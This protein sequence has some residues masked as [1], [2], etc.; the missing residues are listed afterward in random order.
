VGDIV[1]T[2]SRIEGLNKRLGTRI[3]ASEDT[4][5]EA[6]DF[7]KRLMGSFLLSGKSRPVTIYQILADGAF[8]GEATPV[9]TEL[10]PT[11]LELFRARQW[12]QAETTLARCLE[13]LPG[14]GPS[15]FYLEQ[16]RTYQRK[17]PA[18]DWNGDISISK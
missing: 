15:H 2:A 9:Y 3:L 14:D 4:L 6:T 7:D 13:I 11:A 18:R 16:C 8:K 1:N 12:Q 10:F 5:V 17:P